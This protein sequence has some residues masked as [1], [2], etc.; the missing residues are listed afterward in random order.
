MG[1]SHGH[2]GPRQT[3][4]VE[5]PL[6]DGEGE[7]LAIRFQCFAE[8]QVARGVIGDCQRIAISLIAKLK[9]TFVISTPE[10]IGKQ[11]IG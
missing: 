8:Q 1:S 5:E 7:I 10:I 3:A 11:A 9:L 4:F 6:K 2:Y